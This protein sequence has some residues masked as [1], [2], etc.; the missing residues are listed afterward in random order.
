MNTGNTKDEQNSTS[1]DSTNMNHVHLMNIED[2]SQYRS[3]SYEDNYSSHDNTEVI[4]EFGPIKVKPRRKPAL[5]LSTGRRSKYE[6][7]APEDDQ[8]RDVRRARN[9]AAAERVRINRLNIEQELQREIN[10]LEIQEQQLHHT[11]QMLHH[12]KVHLQTRIVT[13]EKVCFSI[14][15]NLNTIVS[16]LPHPPPP[17]QTFKETTSTIDNNFDDLFFETPVLPVQNT[18]ID[19]LS[20]MSPDDIEDYLINP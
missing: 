7:L 16:S 8:K 19:L 3:S 13:H 14:Q 20:T 18:E 4:I 1:N 15:T 11:I 5:T 9:R 6:I 2:E 12:Q 17:I 10:Q